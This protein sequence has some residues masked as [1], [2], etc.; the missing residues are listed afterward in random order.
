MA[1][2]F[3]LMYNTRW[4]ILIHFSNECK[5]F[6]FQL[7]WSTLIALF[8]FCSFMSIFFQLDRLR[9]AK[10]DQDCYV[11][12]WG[13][14]WLSVNSNLSIVIVLISESLFYNQGWKL[15]KLTSVI[16]YPLGVSFKYSLLLHI[17]C[18]YQCDKAVDKNDT[19]EVIWYHFTSEMISYHFT[20]LNCPI[21]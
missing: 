2:K 7:T 5:W 10:T 15:N 14:C 18:G 16:H 12:K 21:K 1:M 11:E 8:L 3:I 4:T 13:S 6:H 19:R 9:D 20:G 17:M